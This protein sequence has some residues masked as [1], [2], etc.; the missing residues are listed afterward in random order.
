MEDAFMKYD[1]AI[2][3]AGVTGAAI[4]LELSKYQLHV[5]VLEK[6]NDVSMHTSKANSAIIHAGYDPLCGTKMARMNVLGSRMVRE[7]AGKLH[8][9]YKQIGSLVIGRK[10]ADKPLIDK[11]YQRGIDNGVEG[12]RLLTTRKEI[13]ALGED[14]LDEDIDYALYAPSAAIVSPWEMTLAFMTNAVYN[15]VELKLNSAVEGI[16]KTEDGFRIS[17][18]SGTYESRYVINAAGL[19]GDDVYAM[20]LGHRDFD[21]VPVKGEYYLLDKDQGDLVRHVIFQTPSKVGKGVLVSPTVHGNLIVGPN[22]ETVQEKDKVN[23]TSAGLKEVREKS[24][25]TTKKISFFGNVRN[26]AGNRATIPGI[27]DFLIEESH[28]VP[29]FINFVGIKS[30]GLSSSPAFG[31]EAVRILT[32]CG[33]DFKIKEHYR[34][35]PLQPFF[36]ELSLAEK[37]T[38]LKENPLYG[39]VICRCESITEGE[40]V[41]AIHQEIP[42]TTIDAVK[43]RCNAGMG[44]C[45]GGFCSPKVFEILMRELHLEYDQVYQDRQGSQIVVCQTKEER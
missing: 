27:D 29:G 37:E 13:L 21:I 1:V 34:Y 18:A 35:K 40:I 33:L 7:L 8:F 25:L 11:L 4:A 39:R 16:E 32:K 15:G 12:L 28:E 5:L 2:I 6:E 24:A 45:Q 19:H 44:R 23:V 10:D 38:K 43:R 31:L 41:D 20:A 9:H 36:K 17:S 42:A 14:N 26:F 22:A 3:G 30:P